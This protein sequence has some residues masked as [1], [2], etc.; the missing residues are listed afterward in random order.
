MKG[1]LLLKV[2]VQRVKEAKVVVDEE[3]IGAISAGLLLLVGF[4][5][6]DTIE[7]VDALTKKIVQLRIFDDEEGKMNQSLLDTGGAILSVS[8]FTLY[9]DCT[10]GRR[11]SFVAAAKPERANF[12]YREFNQ[13]LQHQGAHVETGLFG[14][15]M[16]VFLVNDGPVTFVLE[17]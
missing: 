12:L 3:V 1:A 11:P 13:M 10:K 5:N 7:K 6:E 17:N 4:S 15:N 8:Q 9:G 16:E 2:V 14:A